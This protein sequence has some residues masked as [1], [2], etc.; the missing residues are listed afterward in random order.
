MGGDAT[1]FTTAESYAIRGAM[2]PLNNGYFASPGGEHSGLANFGLAD[3]SVRTIN[4]SVNANVFAMMGSMA[5][6]DSTQP[7]L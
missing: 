5:D 3:G 6:G 1:L 2:S 7:E 4:N